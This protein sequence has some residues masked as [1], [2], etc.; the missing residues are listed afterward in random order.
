MTTERSRSA[1]KILPRESV[2]IPATTPNFPGPL[3]EAP[4]LSREP[5][6]LMRNALNRVA[7]V[8]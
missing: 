8:T 7:A 3:P 6:G 4:K 5:S 1:I 2:Q